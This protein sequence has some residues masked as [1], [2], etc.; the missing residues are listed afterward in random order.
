MSKK[1]TMIFGVKTEGA[2]V[3]A[4][5]VSNVGKAAGES[6]K[7]VGGL[8]KSLESAGDS[9]GDVGS[10]GKRGMGMLSK[11]LKSGVGGLKMLKTALISTGIGAL[12]VAVGALV[13]N[14]QMSEKWSDRLRV[15]SAALGGVFSVVSEA[16]ESLGDFLLA[17]WEN[18]QIAIDAFS[19]KMATIWSVITGVG[20]LIKESFVLTLQTLK[21]WFIQAGISATEFFSAGFADTSG[22]EAALQSVKDDIEETK[23][24]IAEA[25]NQ[26]ATPFVQAF[27]KGKDAL[28]RFTESAKV[29]ANASMAL[30]RRQLMLEKAERK[31]SVQF[32]QS[33]QKIAEYKKDSDDITLSFEERIDAAEK[34]ADIE[35]TLAKNNLTIAEEQVAILKQRQAEGDKTLK[36]AEALAEAEIALADAQ[37]ESLGVQTE[38]MTKING[39]KL[40]QKAAAQEA[41]DAEKARLDAQIALQI[42]ADAVLESEYFNAVE[43]EKRKW[44]ALLA[45]ADA[46]SFE[47]L[48]LE[49]A[50][51][52]KLEQM[53]LAQDK[54]DLAQTRAVNQAKLK[55]ANDAFGALMALNNSRSAKDEAAARKQFETNKAFSYAQA[56]IN[57]ALAIS[58][59]LAK[60]SVAPFSR[61]ASAATA[62]A[63]GVAQVL[64]ISNT[65]FDDSAFNVDDDIPE[66]GGSDAGQGAMATAAE[67]APQID[68][69]FLGEGAGNTIQAYVISEN[70]TNQQQADQL[71]QEQTVL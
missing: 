28:N 69:G 64:A 55:L 42:E 70:V 21:K 3:A 38:L 45:E 43:A 58:D 23:N 33:R 39:L 26:V 67:T 37:I 46:G 9:A 63:M 17:A 8:N 41:A 34:A 71:V 32:A 25:A 7:E 60:D 44:A 56:V 61:Y 5:E 4:K 47:Y 16:I 52:K 2:D 6:S 30:E 14:F 65:Q 35:A 27:N 53:R 11:G 19:D 62:G 66:S 29:A 59:A 48:Q 36:T 49:A 18:P 13:T 24:E 22:M 1:Q 20:S 31:L 50:R 54:K 15:A 12:V 10:K 40:E 57:T 68:L 51:D